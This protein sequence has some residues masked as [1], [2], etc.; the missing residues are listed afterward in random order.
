MIKLGLCLKRL[1]TTL[2]DNYNPN[3]QFRLSK[4]DIKEGF[5]R[6]QVKKRRMELRIRATVLY[7]E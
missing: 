7:S 3:Q 5:W 6:L 2:G 1:T 4:M